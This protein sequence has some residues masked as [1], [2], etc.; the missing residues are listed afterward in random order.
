MRAQCMDGFVKV[1]WA[2]AVHVSSTYW[3]RHRSHGCGSGRAST[4]IYYSCP[5]TVYS[6]FYIAR[7][8]SLTAG[9]IGCLACSIVS[10][11]NPPPNL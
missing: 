6:C 8:V 9:L 4:D 2:A 11:T 10:K 1:P 3:G 7:L 5:R